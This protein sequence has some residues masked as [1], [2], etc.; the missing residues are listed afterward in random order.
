MWW[1]G[2]SIQY[3]VP[4]G[5]KASFFFRGWGGGT[6]TGDGQLQEHRLWILLNSKYYATAARDKLLKLVQ[7]EFGIL[8]RRKML[9]CKLRSHNLTRETHSS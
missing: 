6:E 4:A 5:K 7:S 8:P 2:S 3:G 1:H 9:G